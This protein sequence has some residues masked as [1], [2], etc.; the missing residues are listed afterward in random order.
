MGKKELKEPNAKGNKGETTLTMAN[1]F[2]QGFFIHPQAASL[3]NAKLELWT[4]LELE[5][6]ISLLIYFVNF[7]KM[8]WVAG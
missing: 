4:Q 1:G 2:V 7:L 8:M 3:L 6:Q 5:G